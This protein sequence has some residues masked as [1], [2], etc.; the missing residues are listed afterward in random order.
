MFNVLLVKFLLIVGAVPSAVH[1]SEEMKMPKCLKSPDTSKKVDNAIKECQ[2]SVKLKI[3]QEHLTNDNDLYIH[4]YVSDHETHHFTDHHDPPFHKLHERLNDHHSSLNEYSPP[5]HGHNSPNDHA[6]FFD[7]SP[8]TYDLHSPTNNHHSSF[9]KHGPSIHS[10]GSPNNDHH[11]S[12]TEHGHLTHD[13]H[14]PTNHHHSSFP[15]HSSSTHNHYSS[16]GDHHSSLPEHSPSTHVRHSL[17][18]NHHSSFPEHSPSTHDHYSP[19]G[20]H[21]SSFPEH[22]PPTHAHH[23]PIGDHHSS[24]NQHSPSMHSHNSQIDNHYSSGNEQYPHLTT[25]SPHHFSQDHSL[26]HLSS[27]DTKIKM[28]HTFVHSNLHNP[29]P[30]SN[31]HPSREHLDHVVD[32]MVSYSDNPFEHN[33][34][35]EIMDFRKKRDTNH[36]DWIYASNITYHDKRIAGCIMQCIYEKNDAVD[37]HGWPTLDGLVNFYSEGVNEHG[38][39]MATL[40]AVD[41]C[42]KVSSIKYHVNR[43]SSPENGQTC[44]VAFDVFDCISDEITEYCDD[45]HK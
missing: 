25:N 45:N 15:E 17:T 31:D 36:D 23:S 3:I 40:R 5:I 39:F 44:D 9:D 26:N 8:S 20:D 6:S 42:L 28:P 2:E 18:N 7:H 19:T 14:S 1:C 32:D 21:H 10:H 22:S 13:R 35:M 30:Q 34:H 43:R 4:D 16:S 12:F 29:H 37:K 24:S 33:Q 11:T 27:H 38:Y 41:H